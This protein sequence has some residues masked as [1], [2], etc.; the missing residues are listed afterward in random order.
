MISKRVQNMSPS[1]TLEL[2]SK[3]A[4]LRQEG[5]SIIALNCG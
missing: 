5:L 4:K 1:Q 2:N 3:I